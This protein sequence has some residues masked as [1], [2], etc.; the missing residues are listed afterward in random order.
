MVVKKNLVAAKELFA[1]IAYKRH[2]QYIKHK[3]SEI[4]LAFKTILPA[5]YNVKVLV[6]SKKYTVGS[7]IFFK[8][9]NW[10]WAV[11]LR[12]SR[13]KALVSSGGG[14]DLLSCNWRL[15]SY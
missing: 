3:S 2:S 10:H 4:R 12:V 14:I 7:K 6:L 11:A 1:F 15:R 8:A 13:L 9:I 5:L